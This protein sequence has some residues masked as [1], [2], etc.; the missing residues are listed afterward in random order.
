MN[1]FNMP[2]AMYKA[3][4]AKNKMAKIQ[5]VGRDESVSILINGLSEIEE[6][7]VDI[8]QLANQLGLDVSEENIRK[9]VEMVVKNT[10]KAI[11]DAKK[12]LEKELINSTDMEEL[13]SLLGG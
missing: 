4:Q 7:E 13:K 12:Q 2:K 1:M 9:I 10:K 11:A 6:I 8:E 5:A 3:Q